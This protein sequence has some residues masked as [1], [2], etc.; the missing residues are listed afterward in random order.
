MVF[1]GESTIYLVDGS[2]SGDDIMF[3]G[4]EVTGMSGGVEPSTIVAKPYGAEH[5]GVRSAIIE[6]RLLEVEV[7]GVI[8]DGKEG[9]ER[10]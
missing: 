5:A 6:E 8:E 1:T 7:E 4:T 3:F 9:K 2:S 10:G